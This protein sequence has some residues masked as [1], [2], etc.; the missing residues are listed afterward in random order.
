MRITVKWLEARV[1]R[2][3]RALGFEPDAIEYRTVGAVR[4]YRAYGGY[5]VQ[6]VLSE[7]GAVET[8][9]PCVTARECD[10]F[11][12]GMIAGLEVVK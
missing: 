3:N 1:G 11:L 10:S 12:S 8:L 4:L 6:R 9:S 2:I 7:G 5:G